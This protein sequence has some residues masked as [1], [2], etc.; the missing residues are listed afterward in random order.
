MEA[1][2]SSLTRAVE[3][4]PA[5]ALG[6]ALVWGILSI[7]LSPCHLASIPL[8]VG[9]IDDQGKTT[10]GR[11]LWTST[12][13][14]TGILVTIAV[15][16]IATALAGRM[17]GDL[18]AYANYFVALIF[19]YV[20]LGL[21]GVVPLSWNKPEHVGEKR[22]GFFA[23]FMLGLIFGI[24]LGPCSFA[25]MAPMLGIA[26]KLGAEQPIY[27]GS[28][29]LMYGLGHCGVIAIAGVSAGWVQKYKDWNQESRGAFRLKKIC[30]ILVILGGLYLIYT[31]P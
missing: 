13:F 14:A 1:L 25:Y 6:T 4:T 21:L 15:I 8:I 7:L 30:G 5:I 22:K 16:G 17:L 23:A 19:F 31:A 12:L 28:L 10:T 18:G 27:A 2:F 9:F 24:A 3:G 26:F 11:A 29:L 20:G